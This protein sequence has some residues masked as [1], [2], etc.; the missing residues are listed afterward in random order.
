MRSTTDLREGA[1]LMTKQMR[2]A[3]GAEF[4]WHT[5]SVESALV[6]VEGTAT[7]E[8]SDRSE[9][10]GPGDTLIIPADIPHRVV[11][12]PEFT[13]VHV[14]PNEIRFNFNLSDLQP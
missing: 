13:A 8:F 5:A 2:G 12:T 9:E 14:M 4:P 3:G 6:M 11:A 7:I 10:L 1:A